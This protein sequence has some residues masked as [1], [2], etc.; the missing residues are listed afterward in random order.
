MSDDPWFH[1]FAEKASAY[2]VKVFR[3]PW[4]NQETYWKNY[5]EQ[6]RNTQLSYANA[7]TKA[8]K[9]LSKRF[10]RCTHYSL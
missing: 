6:E 5:L 4:I 7:L 9:K 3:M 2:A 10:T 8:N 1:G